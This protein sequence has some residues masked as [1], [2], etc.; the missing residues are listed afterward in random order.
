MEKEEILNILDIR[1]ADLK[2]VV[3]FTEECHVPQYKAPALRGG[4]GQMILQKNCIGDKDCSVC[5]FE[6]ECLLRRMLYARYDEKFRPKFATQRESNG[7]VIECENRQE[8]FRRGEQ[9]IFHLILFGKVIVHFSHFLEAFYLLGQ[10]TGLGS[11][12][13]HYQIVR[14]ENGNGQ[15]TVNQNQVWLKQLGISTIREYAVKRVRTLMES[16]RKNLLIFKS[17]VSIKYAGD[18]IHEFSEEALLSSLLRRIY[19]LNL[20]EE[21]EVSTLQWSG[22]IPQIIFQKAVPAHIT[23]Y[24]STQ[25][26]KMQLHGI[27]GRV[28]FDTFSEELLLLFTAGEKLHIGKNSSFGFGH[29]EIQ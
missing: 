24:S 6:T 22:S 29:Y 23:R 28:A 17:P 13:A 11:G 18:F 14:V 2:F 1:F 16:S 10:T 5:T 20:F 7:Y 19:C 4:M 27:I 26:E 15:L 21:K 3:E 25:G 12:H 8:H 9:M